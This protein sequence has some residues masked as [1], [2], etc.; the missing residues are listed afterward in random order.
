[1]RR[2]ARAGR[3]VAMM[4]FAFG[5]LAPG[6]GAAF[7]GD[8]AFATG[9]AIAGLQVGGGVQNNIADD[10]PITG[11]AFVNVTPRLSYLPFAPFGRGMLRSAI[12]PGLEGWFQTYFE[13]RVFTAEG[14]K[15]ALRYHFIGLGPLV[16]YL[17]LTGGAAG[18][19]LNVPEIRSAFTFVIEGGA[20]VSYFVTPD[21]ALN[22]GY[23]VQHISNGNTSGPNRGVNSN[24]GVFGVSYYF[25]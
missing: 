24:T 15:V 3:L 17:E 14:L 10:P 6:S 18:T 21:V 1:M 16:P 7:D 11:I 23:R 19:N 8:A 13:P 12:E 4:L 20:G 9:T 25:H 5:A 2:S 22:L